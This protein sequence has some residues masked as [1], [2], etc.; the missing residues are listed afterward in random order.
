MDVRAR[1]SRRLTFGTA[2][3]ANPV[4]SPDG[5]QIVFA[6][7]DDTRSARVLKDASGSGTEQVMF[8]TG[9]EE[10]RVDRPGDDSIRY[11]LFTTVGKNVDV[12]ALPTGGDRKPFAVLA[13]NWSEGRAQFSPDGRFIAYTAPGRGQLGIHAVE[14]VRHCVFNQGESQ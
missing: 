8:T 1:T 10:S 13:E 14:V 12:W 7:Q 6:R 11:I 4:W 2:I 9:P 3:D 5:K